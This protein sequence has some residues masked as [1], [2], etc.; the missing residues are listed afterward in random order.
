MPEYFSRTNIECR[1]VSFPHADVTIG[2]T[3]SPSMGPRTALVCVM[4]NLQNFLEISLNEELREYSWGAPYFRR[5]HH[6]DRGAARSGRSRDKE[7][8]GP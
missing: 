5:R 7:R 6:S 3:A 4:R 1:Q 2:D 8:S